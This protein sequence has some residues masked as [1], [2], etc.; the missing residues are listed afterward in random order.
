MSSAKW[1]G[2]SGK[3]IADRWGLRRGCAPLLVS[4]CEFKRAIVGCRGRGGENK[5]AL[6]ALLKS[7]GVAGRIS[8]MAGW[9]EGS[10]LQE[11]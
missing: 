3:W 8:W 7:W 4:G 11:M 10:G 5:Q 9:L 6:V 2:T 1:I